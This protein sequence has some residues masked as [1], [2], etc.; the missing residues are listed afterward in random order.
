MELKKEG[1][2]DYSR[3]AINQRRVVGLKSVLAFLFLD[4]TIILLIDRSVCK[5]TFVSFEKLNDYLT[6]LY[7]EPNLQSCNAVL[8]FESFYTVK[9]GN[10]SFIFTFIG[11]SWM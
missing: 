4:V 7:P 8:T 11:S 5:L 1:W 6:L 3:E 2:V 10:F 9:F